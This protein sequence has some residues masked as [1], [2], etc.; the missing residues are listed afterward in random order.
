VLAGKFVFI[1]GRLLVVGI[2]V[3]PPIVPL[4]PLMLELVAEVSVELPGVPWLQPTSANVARAVIAENVMIDF[5]RSLFRVHCWLPPVLPPLLPPRQPDVRRRGRDQVTDHYFFM[6]LMCCKCDFT[7]GI[8][9]SRKF[10][11]SGSCVAV[12]SALNALA[13]FLWPLTMAA[14]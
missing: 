9:L 13:S 1:S 7:T 2:L 3:L 14:I 6:A 8:D 12:D 10:L 5:I 4:A 11:I